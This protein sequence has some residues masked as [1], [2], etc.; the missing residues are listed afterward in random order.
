LAGLLLNLLDG[1][2]E[3]V[4]GERPLIMRQAAD[5]FEF[6]G[7]V[8]MLGLVVIAKHVGGQSQRKLCRAG[9][10]IAPFKTAVMLIS[11]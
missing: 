11:T 1:L 8:D 7:L 5:Y 2:A 3:L 6:Q 10:S 9:S 4:L